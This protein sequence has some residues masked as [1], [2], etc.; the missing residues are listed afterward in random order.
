MSLSQTLSGSLKSLFVKP[1]HYYSRQG[2]MCENMISMLDLARKQQ[3]LTPWFETEERSNSSISYRWS[4]LYA[5][6]KMY[7]VKVSPILQIS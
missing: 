5:V 7:T 6:P 2:D 3:M 4:I 1:F